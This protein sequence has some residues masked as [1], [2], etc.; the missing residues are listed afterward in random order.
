MERKIRCVH[1]RGCRRGADWY[2]SRRHRLYERTSARSTIAARRQPHKNGARLTSHEGV[3]HAHRCDASVAKDCRRI[4]EIGHLVSCAGTDRQGADQTTTTIEF[5]DPSFSLMDTIFQVR[6]HPIRGPGK[7]RAAVRG[8]ADVA[9]E[10]GSAGV[11]G[12]CPAD[13]SQAVDRHGKAIA[14]GTTRS[15]N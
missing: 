1:R 12:V 8:C 4:D 13:P 6:T 15:K 9:D 2:D 3:K 7:Y 10:I 5:H 14:S 11:D